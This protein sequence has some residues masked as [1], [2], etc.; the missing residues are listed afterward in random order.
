[1]MGC[2]RLVAKIDGVIGP[3]EDGEDFEGDG[4]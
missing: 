1:M 2:Y 4:G 3:K